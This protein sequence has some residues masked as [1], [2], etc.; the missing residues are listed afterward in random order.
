MRVLPFL[1]ILPLIFGC[2]NSSS[3]EAQ[4]TEGKSEELTCYFFFISDCPA[5]RNNL[6]KMQ[7]ISDQYPS[8]VKVI[9]VVSDPLLD[10]GKLDETLAE[11][12]V[13]FEVICD[14]NLNIARKHGATVTPQIMLYDGEK[15][16]YSGK[17]DDYYIKLGKHKYEPTINYVD[18]AIKEWK[19]NKEIQISETPL[20]G[21]TINF[22]F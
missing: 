10:Q 8:D 2:S 13:T 20:V 14:T 3:T 19:E 1:L 21:C 12:A 17:M 18:L 4:K 15:R 9:G 16:I 22:D 7:Q 6:P 11:M 5:S